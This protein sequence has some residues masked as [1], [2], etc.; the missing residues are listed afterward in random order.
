MSILIWKDPSV[1]YSLEISE[2]LLN[3]GK[4]I[5][6]SD[7]QSFQSIDQ[8]FIDCV[9]L[10]CPYFKETDFL[11]V[12]K[13]VEQKKNIIVIEY[14]WDINIL[15]LFRNHN[16][17]VKKKEIVFNEFKISFSKACCESI[18]I[19]KENRS[20]KIKGDNEIELTKNEFNLFYFLFENIGRIINTEEIIKRVWSGL[21]SEANVYMTI[22]KIRCK[23]ETNPKYPRLLV[24]QRGGGYILKYPTSNLG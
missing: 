13:Q 2:I 18:Q 16:F 12:R 20:I 15:T 17:I 10:D 14:S 4:F 1:V 24:T 3:T 19:N 23:V 11:N 6:V 21:T 9:I 7:I 22:Q 5:I 8:C